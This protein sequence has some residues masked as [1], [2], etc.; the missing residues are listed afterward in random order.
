MLVVSQLTQGKGGAQ[1]S[2]LS[3]KTESI[4]F[5]TIAPQHIFYQLHQDVLAQLTEITRGSLVTV[6]WVH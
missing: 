6:N 3:V 2:R 1:Y 4:S 5:S